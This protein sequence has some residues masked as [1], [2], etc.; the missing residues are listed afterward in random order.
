R[1]D[2]IVGEESPFIP[3]GPFKLR[4][5]FIHYR[6]EWPDYFQGLLMC[7]VDLAAI[8]LMIELLGMPFD[9]ALAV[10]LMNGL[11]PRTRCWKASR[12][13]K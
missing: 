12:N 13:K 10:V 2:R 7:A 9:V 8:P 3:L 4:L 5:P 11:A 1:K 6:F